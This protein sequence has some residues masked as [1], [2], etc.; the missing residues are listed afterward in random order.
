MAVNTTDD[1]VNVTDSSP[2]SVTDEI[3]STI[4]GLLNNATNISP[5]VSVNTPNVDDIT[6]KRNAY[7]TTDETTVGTSYFDKDTSVT[8]TDGITGGIST[9]RAIG[10]FESKLVFL[11]AMKT[12]YYVKIKTYFD[13]V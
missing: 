5:G 4:N 10:T 3:F 8:F 7:A 11:E 9:D 2:L 12:T 13:Y 6:S 1:N